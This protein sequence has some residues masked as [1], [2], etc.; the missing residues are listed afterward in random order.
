MPDSAT[1]SAEVDG[2]VVGSVSAAAG[3]VTMRC[4]MH[5]PK[6]RA[7][8]MRISSSSTVNHHAMGLSSDV[9][10]LGARIDEIVFD[11]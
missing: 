7:T 3:T 9:R 8:S 6:G 11:H 5:V 4:D 10:D 1:I 2:T